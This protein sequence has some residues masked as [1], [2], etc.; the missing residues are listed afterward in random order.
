MTVTSAALGMA[1]AAVFLLAGHASAQD[2]TS[3]TRLLLIQDRGTP[4]VPETAGKTGKMDEEK[5]A[6][7]PNKIIPKKTSTV[8]PKTPKTTPTAAATET[9]YSKQP[10]SLTKAPI[11]CI[12]A[13]RANCAGP[14]KGKSACGPVYDSCVA[15]C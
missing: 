9:A 15:A 5:I 4:P 14:K 2:S 11:S 10:K 13:C 6:P 1:M 3:R 12:E 8:T 7:R